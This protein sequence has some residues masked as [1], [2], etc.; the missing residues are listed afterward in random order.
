M[1]NSA[2]IG[3]FEKGV[4]KGFSLEGLKRS[5]VKKG[6]DVKEVDESLNLFKKSKDKKVKTPK[7]N[8]FGKYKSEN[9]KIWV[10]LSFSLAFVL[11]IFILFAIFSSNSPR[12]ISEEKIL[13]GTSFELR[14]GKP[15]TFMLSNEEH[16]IEADSIRSNS[17]EIT[18]SSEP[19]NFILSIGESKKVDL[20]GEGFYDLNVEL[21]GIKNVRAE[22]YVE[23]INVLVCEEDWECGDWSGCVAGEGIRNCV[24]LNDCGTTINRPLENKVCLGGSVSGTKT[25]INGGDISDCNFVAGVC[26]DY[27]YSFCCNLDSSKVGKKSIENYLGNGFCD[28]SNINCFCSWDSSSG[29]SPSYGVYDL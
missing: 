17:V 4:S 20:D 22:I 27:V 19:V 29:C 9:R 15:V 25:F 3:Y 14:E 26:S 8:S 10:I 18:I 21:R 1:A 5:L 13:E 2:L 7:K 23:K 11:I 28:D 6:W 24:D 16:I 12:N